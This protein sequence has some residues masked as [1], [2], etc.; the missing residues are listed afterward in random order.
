[1]PG[2]LQNGA[3]AYYAQQQQ[4]SPQVQRLQ[5]FVGSGAGIPVGRECGFGI[6]GAGRAYPPSWTYMKDWTS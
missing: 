2:Q 6:D 3:S 5:H 4:Q 1:M